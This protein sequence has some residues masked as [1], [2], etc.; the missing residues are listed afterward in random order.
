[1]T[2][3]HHVA[4]AIAAT[5]ST[6]P[7]Y[8]VELRS[9]AHHLVADEPTANG[10]AD[11]GPSPFGLVL[12][13]LAAC[14]AMTLRMYAERKGWALASIEVDVRYDVAEGGA[15]S[16]ERTITVPADLPVEQRDRLA[17]IAE[18]TPVTLAV[19]AGT[20]ITTWVEAA[21]G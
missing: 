8:R 15:A 14:T 6:K 11:T 3:T 21:S 18:R 1:M 4:R 17:D 16:I 10:G 2:T 9:G 7:A 5:G 12:S 20:P 13:G 19:R